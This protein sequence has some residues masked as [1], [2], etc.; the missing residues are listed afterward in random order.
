M[1]ESWFNESFIFTWWLMAEQVA[2]EFTSVR[3][4]SSLEMDNLQLTFSCWRPFFCWQILA[5][6]SQTKHIKST[7][8]PWWK[9]L[10]GKKNNSVRGKKMGSWELLAI[11]WRNFTLEGVF[12]SSAYLGVIYK[13]V[14]ILCFVCFPGKLVCLIGFLCGILC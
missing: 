1:S 5:P 2:S 4:T 6:S 13:K 14:R 7:L 11:K 9:K 3:W 8:R 12:A 10:Q